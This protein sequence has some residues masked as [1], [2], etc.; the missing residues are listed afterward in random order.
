MQ[1]YVI[2]FVNDLRRVCGFTPGTSVFSINK[3]DLHDIAEILLKVSLNVL[4]LNALNMLCKTDSE[5][6]C[7]NDLTF[8]LLIK[9]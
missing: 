9:M 4:T 1:H 7:R 8:A 5:Y 2:K 6:N 3:T